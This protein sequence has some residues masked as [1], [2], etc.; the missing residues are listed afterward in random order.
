MDSTQMQRL[1]A[2]EE[3]A[4]QIAKEDLGLNFHDIE[5]DV[6]P[7]EKMFEIMAYNFIGGYSNWKYGRDMERAR[8]IYEKT[9]EGLPYEVVVNTN[10][11]RAYLMKNNTLAVQ[12]LVVTHVIGHAAFSY[13]NTNHATADKDLT[14][15]LIAASKRF[16]EYERKY[17]IEAVEKIQDAGHA[18]M[19]HSTPSLS[20]ETEDEKRKRIFEQIKRKAHERKAT[21]FDDFLGDE[22]Y[23]KAQTERDLYNH[24]I[25]MRLKARTPVEPTEDLLRY[26][27]DNSRV[28]SDW[29]KD[30]LEIIR[31]QGRF[32]HPMIKTKQ[33]NEGFAT[34]THQKIMQ[35]LFREGYL[36]ATD[37]AEYNYSNSLVKAKSKYSMNPYLVG[38]EMWLDIEKRWNK[39][40]YGTEWEGCVDAERK[41][42]WDTGE[43]NGL[44]KIHKILRTYSDW[45]FM[46]DFLTADLIRELQLYLYK[47][48]KSILY[49]KQVVITDHKVEEIRQ[50]IVKSFAHSGIP[51]IEVA[52][53]N[54]HGKGTLLLKHSHIGPDL[55]KEYAEKT[56]EHI[57]WLWGEDVELITRVDKNWYSYKKPNPHR[58]ERLGDSVGVPQPK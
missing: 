32:I 16:E 58:V 49:T 6:V 35:K 1:I 24:K 53:G 40:Q 44:K 4:Y 52:D 28:L 38:S 29:E 18:I 23:K 51:K 43:M 12:A 46:N 5:F 11:V 41:K 7:K 33:M 27:I 50:L 9:G 21:E 19:W 25:W 31:M 20:E 17:G 8:T 36:N 15:K 57:A 54:G 45:S 13:H 47:A 2:I 10:P 56:L 30:I 26:I 37:H 3:R 34:W 55:D 14:S 42:N 22:F 48:Q 39:G